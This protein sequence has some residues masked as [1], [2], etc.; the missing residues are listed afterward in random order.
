MLAVTQNTVS[1]C[2]PTHAEGAK[3]HPPHLG[4]QHGRRCRADAHVTLKLKLKVCHD[5][6]TRHIV[7]VHAAIIGER[8]HAHWARLLDGAATPAAHAVIGPI[9]TEDDVPQ[10]GHLRTRCYLTNLRT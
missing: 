3:L 6:E 9:T 4:Q 5:V 10:V 7:R 1:L 8:C 2:K